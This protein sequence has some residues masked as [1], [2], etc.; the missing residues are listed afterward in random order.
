MGKSEW[1]EG[2]CRRHQAWRMCF[3]RRVAVP[4]ILEHILK[5]EARPYQ[6]CS[7]SVSQGV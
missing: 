3:L 7:R 5:L 4:E 6:T 1:S 2:R